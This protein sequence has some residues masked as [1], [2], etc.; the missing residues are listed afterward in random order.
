MLPTAKG[1]WR[2]P[3][4]GA[5]GN[6]RVG[7]SFLRLLR[8]LKGLVLLPGDPFGKHRGALVP[9]FRIGVV[10]HNCSAEFGNDCAISSRVPV[11]VT[12]VVLLPR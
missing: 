12:A 5:P 3:P 9:V 11:G 1:E 7:K 4:H 10:E 8:L 6:F 2:N